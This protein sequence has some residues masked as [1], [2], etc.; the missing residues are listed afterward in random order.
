MYHNIIK[1]K[2]NKLKTRR[3]LKM[4]KL[5]IIIAILLLSVVVSCTTDRR[6]KD[7]ELG[8]RMRSLKCNE[9]FNITSG[10]RY[11]YMFKRLYYANGMIDFG[12]TNYLYQECKKSGCVFYDLPINDTSYY[13]V[14]INESQITSV[15]ADKSMSITKICGGSYRHSVDVGQFKLTLLKYENGITTVLV[16]N[17]S[18]EGFVYAQLGQLELSAVKATDLKFVSSTCVVE[19]IDHSRVSFYEYIKSGK[20]T[21]LIEKGYIP[22][23]SNLFRY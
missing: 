23:F 17:K 10:G 8:V 5:F 13:R 11:A 14:S 6:E 21:K 3:S 4:K 18:T 19:I 7:L 2:I 12:G 9:T 22:D 20:E 16:E 1:Q 15:G